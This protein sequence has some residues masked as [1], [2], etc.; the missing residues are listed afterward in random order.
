VKELCHRL[1]NS[2]YENRRAAVRR[3]RQS[4]RNLSVT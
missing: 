2:S 3:D 4:P 1:K